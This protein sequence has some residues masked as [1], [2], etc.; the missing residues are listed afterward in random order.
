MM[1]LAK[2]GGPGRLREVRKLCKLM[3]FP[4]FF[5]R[6]HDAAL[7]LQT[8]PALSVSG[9]S[10]TATRSL[11]NLFLPPSEASFWPKF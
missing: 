10:N 9:C 1:S 6:F 5:L 7:Y 2:G 3:W 4:S 8:N 11:T